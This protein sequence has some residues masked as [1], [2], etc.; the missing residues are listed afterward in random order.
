MASEAPPNQRGFL[1]P[2]TETHRPVIEPVRAWRCGLAPA[3]YWLPSQPVPRS[4]VE[5]AI[6]HNHNYCEHARC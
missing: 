6:V 2:K 5:V 4:A 3:I 1:L